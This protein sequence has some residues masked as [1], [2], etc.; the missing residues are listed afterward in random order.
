MNKKSGVAGVSGVSSDFRDLTA[1][2]K[3]G[4]TRAQLALDMF[5]YQVKEA[6]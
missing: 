4:N 3:E 6:I 1:A 5:T 2:S